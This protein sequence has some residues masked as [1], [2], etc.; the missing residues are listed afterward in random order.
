M[1]MSFEKCYARH[2]GNCDGKSREHVIS[3]V[4]LESLA[5]FGVQGF[6]WLKPGETGQASPNSLT[7][8]VLCKHHNGLL[9]SYDAEAAKLFAHLKL[10][11]SKR[12]PNEL[13]TVPQISIDGIRFERWLLKVLCG[14]QASGNFQ[15]N[16]KFFGKLSPSQY[17][18]DLL[19]RDEPW[20][21]GIGLYIDFEQRKRLNAFRGLGYD[22]IY[23]MTT[24]TNAMICGIDIHLWGFPF[25]GLFAV[26]EDGSFLPGYRPPKLEIVNGEVRKEITFSWPEGTPCNSWP[27]LTRD[28]T[29]PD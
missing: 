20:K 21:L 4:I 5:P 9:S 25:R 10:I 1:I 22:P 27:T 26:H 29:N 24:P 14:I 13:G 7:A 15:V 19:Y 12:T 18:I 8:T 2:L 3:R 16:G 11:D 28:G 23:V 6:P 17:M